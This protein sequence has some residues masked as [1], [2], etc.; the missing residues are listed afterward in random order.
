MLFG[1]NQT[2]NVPA[3]YEGA[4]VSGV[5][6]SGLGKFP[7][8]FFDYASEYVPRDLTQ[9]FGWAEYLYMTFGTYRAA[10]RRVVRY[11]LTEL[12][13][14]G[15]SETERERFRKLLEDELNIMQVLSEIG[16]DFMVYGQCFIS[17]YFPFDRLL[18]CPQ[19]ATRYH[20]EAVAYRLDWHRLVFHAHC[21]K[22]GYQGAFGRDD[23]RSM[24]VTRVRI[25]RWNPKRIRIRVHEISGDCEYYYEPDPRFVQKLQEGNRYYLNQTP[26][27]VI[28]AC[29]KAGSEPPLFGFDR[30]AIY[31]LRE[32]TLAGLPIRGWAIPPVMP[33]FKLAYYIQLLRRYDEAIAL[34]Y[35]I[36]FRVLYPESGGFDMRN[37]PLQLGTMETFV[38]AM[39][40]MV[41]AKRMNSV[42]LQVS[43]IKIGYEM[44]GGEANALSPKDNTAYALD[45]FL[46]AI[47]FPAELYKGSLSI[48]AFPV[49]LRLFEKTWGALSDGNNGFL[50][51]AGSRINRYFGW[52]EVGASLRSV[53]LADDIELKAM[54]LQAAAGMDI[55]KTTAFR[56]LGLEFMDEQRKVLEEQREI[57]EMQQEAL[58]EQEA[59]QYDM[60]GGGGGAGPGGQP[61]ATPGDVHAHAREL[62]QNL[63]FNVPETLRRGEIIKIKHSNPT[64]HALVLQELDVQRRELARQ[65]QAMMM[66]NMQ[67]PG[68][69]MAGAGELPSPMALGIFISQEV[70]DCTR[71]H[72]RKIAAAIP[73]PIESLKSV[74]Q[75]SPELTAFRFLY[76]RLRGWE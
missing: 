54:S 24:D 56:P 69:K 3:L 38:S 71:R 61:G 43:P 47:G 76:R 25:I 52:G 6:R 63:L 50:R 64:L 28:E 29:A 13:L 8:P 27:P 49:A 72:L 19:C 74:K 7:S 60:P 32:A 68:V 10:A 1:S 66:Q 21:V 31:H 40:N 51:W 45:E 75:G 46:N 73:E 2:Q 23:I 39:H 30:G 37:D 15:E 17:I 26:W 62:A 42:D 16:D 48:Q 67:Q 58:E 4:G 9:V 12:V 33:N 57:M 53:K 59:A 65:G 41:H 5:T 34:D 20:V 55:S 18:I 22:C 36:P 44:L 70:L 14:E 11:F 35:I